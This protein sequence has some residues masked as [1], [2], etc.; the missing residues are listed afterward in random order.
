[1]KTVELNINESI[2][3][4]VMFFLN[5]IS[6]TDIK[7]VEKSQ[8]SQYYFKQNIGDFFQ[9]SPLVD[10]ISLKREKE[11]YDSRIIF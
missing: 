9:N 2:A 4:K 1:M 6:K 3:D 10:T 5:N 7:V 8:N 11:I